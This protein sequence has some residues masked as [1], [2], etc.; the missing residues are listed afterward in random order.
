VA[1]AWA[2][3]RPRARPLDRAIG[4]AQA[5][6][7][8][9][10]HAAGVGA[11]L[12]LGD[13]SDQRSGGREVVVLALELVE[14]LQRVAQAAHELLVD[15]RQRVGEHL[16]EAGHVEALRQLGL[17][18]LADHL[19]HLLVELGRGEAHQLAAQGLLVGGRAVVGR[20]PPRRAL[21]GQLAAHDRLRRAVVARGV[22]E[23]Q[24][25]TDPL[26]R[27]EVPAVLDPVGVARGL[28]PDPAGQPALLTVLVEAAEL[29]PDVADPLE[30][31]PLGMGVGAL[32]EVPAHRLGRRGERVELARRDVAVEHEGDQQLQRLALARRVAPPQGQ[33]AFLGAERLVGVL[34]EADHAHAVGAHA[35]NGHAISICSAR[36]GRATAAR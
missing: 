22:G 30:R 26:R 32:D 29:R 1:A 35:R 2:S 9:A 21:L 5:V 33:A 28:Q 25:G 17:A 31:A 34:V 4:L 13:R 18:Q 23:V 3:A 8:Q 12:A 11:V 14:L 20:A 15:C 10:H 16:R 36:G 6:G 19:Q 7:A 27:G 24:A